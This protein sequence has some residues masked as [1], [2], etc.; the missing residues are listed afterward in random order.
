MLHSEKRFTFPGF[1]VESG[2]HNMR[3][4]VTVANYVTIT[5]DKSKKTAYLI[6]LFTGMFGGHYYYVGRTMRG[7][8]ATFTLNFA[9]IGW[10]LDLR[11]IRKGKFKDNVG[12]YLRQ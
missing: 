1:V 8:I 3:E 9:F 5:S 10:I 11:K 6:C 7:L 12:Q 2:Y 4:A